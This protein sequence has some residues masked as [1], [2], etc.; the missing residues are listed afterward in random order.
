MTT[1]EMNIILQRGQ[2]NWP[3]LITGR[4]YYMDGSGHAKKFEIQPDQAPAR[5]KIRPA[6]LDLIHTAFDLPDW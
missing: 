4:M 5:H 6:D 2:H 1:G 3:G